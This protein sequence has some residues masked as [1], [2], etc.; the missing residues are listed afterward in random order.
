[1]KEQQKFLRF[2]FGNLAEE[3]VFLTANFATSCSEIW[4]EGEWES[5]SYSPRL[6]PEFFVTVTPMGLPSVLPGCMCIAGHTLDLM[7]GDVPPLAE[8]HI[9]TSCGLKLRCTNPVRA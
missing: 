8:D 5:D 1:M 9:I 2:L 4:Q 6:T 7:Y 3:V